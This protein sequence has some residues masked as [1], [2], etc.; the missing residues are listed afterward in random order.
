MRRHACAQVDLAVTAEFEAA[1][2]EICRLKT[3]LVTACVRA[4][5]TV[6]AGLRGAGTGAHTT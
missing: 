3:Q 2:A 1:Y 4:C 5:M 6:S